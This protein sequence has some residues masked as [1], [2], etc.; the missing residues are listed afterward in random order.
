MFVVILGVKDLE[1]K[2]NVV[3]ILSL[4]GIMGIAAQCWGTKKLLL[5]S[6]TNVSIKLH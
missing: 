2:Y 3:S 4:V 1:A 5:N 6:I